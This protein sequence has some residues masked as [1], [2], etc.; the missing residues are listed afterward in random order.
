MELLGALDSK[1]NLAILDLSANGILGPD[2]TRY[3][4]LALLCK[5]T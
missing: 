4:S 2:H 5:V 1:P 3:T